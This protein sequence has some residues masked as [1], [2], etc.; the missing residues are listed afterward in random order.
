MIAAIT[1]LLH[2]S[3][4]AGTSLVGCDP[5]NRTRWFSDACTKIGLEIYDVRPGPTIDHHRTIEMFYPTMHA[6]GASQE[7]VSLLQK[8][9]RSYRI[10]WTH[11]FLEIDNNEGAEN[12]RIR[13]RWHYEPRRARMI[14]RGTVS[15]GGSYDL[16][17]GYGKAESIRP[18]PTEAYC[19]SSRVGKFGR[20]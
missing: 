13:Y 20:C 15:R 9:G 11:T 3:F 1:I 18:L 4:A 2:S 10:L 12:S 7:S 8:R 19:Y 14:V 6:T 16:G 5:A 17:T